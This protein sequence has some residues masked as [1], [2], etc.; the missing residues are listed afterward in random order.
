MADRNRKNHETYES[1]M[2]E[3]IYEK[4]MEL[5]KGVTQLISEND[6]KVF[7]K[8]YA[9]L[10]LELLYRMDK[11]NNINLTVT[12]VHYNKCFEEYDKLYKSLYSS[13]LESFKINLKSIVE[14]VVYRKFIRLTEEQY[15]SYVISVQNYFPYTEH[16]EC[17]APLLDLLQ[18]RNIIPKKAT[19]MPKNSRVCQQCNT[20]YDLNEKIC[21]FCLR[22]L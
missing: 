10:F 2:S 22:F 11:N 12:N 17:W 1:I 16:F 5:F 6:K 19:I 15:N 7:M 21:V 13:N 4:L 18:G 20:Q 8:I 9:T 14:Y 3:L